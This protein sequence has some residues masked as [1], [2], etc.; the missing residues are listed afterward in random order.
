MACRSSAKLWNLRVS[1][2]FAAVLL[3]GCDNTNIA[4]CSG[5]DEFCSD[6]YDKTFGDDDQ[7][8]PP[9]AG[10]TASE[11]ALAIA[12]DTPQVIESAIAQ[13]TMPD[14]IDANPDLVGLWL[15]AS[16]LG[17]LIDAD[18]VAVSEFLDQ[19]RA[20][21]TDTATHGRSAALTQGLSLF[22]EFATDKDPALA[23]T[24]A[25]QVTG[26]AED[27]SGGAGQGVSGV[28]KRIVVGHNQ[29]S[30]CGAR[31]LAAASIVLCPTTL[32]QNAS[33]GAAMRS[34]CANATQWLAESGSGR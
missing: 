28:A 25:S 13:Q 32:A 7:P 33:S 30:C 3:A 4:F 24:A 1:L 34:A 17:K 27:P 18:H 19:N 29:D 15:T 22:A 2:V 9:N 21:L 8:N 31:A 20:W 14:I 11:L 16:T 10:A 23:Q 26:S 12:N 5:S 6:F